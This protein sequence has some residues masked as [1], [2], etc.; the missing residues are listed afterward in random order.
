MIFLVDVS[1]IEQPSVKNNVAGRNT[2]SQV[3]AGR[4]PFQR[5]GTSVQ[6]R[7]ERRT[8]RA[9]RQHTMKEGQF[10]HRTAQKG[11]GRDQRQRGR[12]QRRAGGEDLALNHGTGGRS[13]REVS[14]ESQAESGEDENALPKTLAGRLRPPHRDRESIKR[15][16]AICNSIS[17][18][19]AS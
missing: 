5:T 14:E 7:T 2:G 6:S 19:A 9:G 12:T 16:R 17:C 10:Q 15:A 4:R 13:N 8:S 1:V 11:E 3:D 18:A